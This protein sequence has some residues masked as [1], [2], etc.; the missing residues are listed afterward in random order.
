MSIAKT[1]ILLKKKFNV[2]LLTLLL[3][4]EFKLTFLKNSF[5]FFWEVVFVFFHSKQ[6]T[7]N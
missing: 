2:F 5:I 4:A 7:E 6:E 3:S 1:F